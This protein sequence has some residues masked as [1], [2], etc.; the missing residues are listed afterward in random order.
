VISTKPAEPPAPVK[1]PAPPAPTPLFSST[2]TP[3]TLAPAASIPTPITPAASVVPQIVT[4][5]KTTSTPLAV[6][7]QP[8]LVLSETKIFKAAEEEENQPAPEK[9]AGPSMRP[10]A[11]S[12]SSA[13]LGSSV[14][15]A[16]ID[17]LETELTGAR[18]SKKS[19]STFEMFAPL[20]KETTDSADDTLLDEPEDS[21]ATLRASAVPAF[22]GLA[23][24]PFAGLDTSERK[25]G[26]GL[27]IGGLAVAIVIGGFAAAWF[28]APD[29]QKTL[30]WEYSKLQNQIHPAQPKLAPL[31]VQVSPAPA[32][33]ATTA[34]SDPMTNSAS[35][36]PPAASG[37]SSLPAPANTPSQPAPSGPVP[38]PAPSAVPAT[39]SPTATAAVPAKS[40]ATPPPAPSSPAPS[41]NASLMNASATTTS[42]AKPAE[43]FEVPEDY[44]DDQVVHRVHPLYPKVARARKLQGPVVLQ[45]IID[46]Q[47]K[48]DSLQLVSGD[49]LLAQAAAD[50]VKQW[51]YKPYSHNGDPV[52]FQTRV[53]VDFKLPLP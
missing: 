15:D 34:S 5:E 40:P 7:P 22:G 32:V 26:R 29:F 30:T 45:A 27:L 17:K 2:S 12:L 52:E 37:T 48:V 13:M 38:A 4:A 33:P 51:R 43:L 19:G 44:A 49:P 20:P 18:E 31:A 47:G 46:K 53:T 6:K 39:H 14:S 9:H 35:T 25:G 24:Q 10:P 11:L 50:A 23:K 16:A 28:Y 36:M 42:V 21:A 1:I 3:A 41:G 8:S